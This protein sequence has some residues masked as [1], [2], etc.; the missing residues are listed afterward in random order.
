[1]NIYT[2]CCRVCTPFLVFSPQSL[3]SSWCW[4][5]LP[6]YR[7]WINQSILSH[8]LTP[9][10]CIFLSWA[11]FFYQEILFPKLTLQKLT[12][13]NSRLL[14]V[15]VS[16]LSFYSH[17]VL[18]SFSLNYYFACGTILVVLLQS[19]QMIAIVFPDLGNVLY[20]Q[21]CIKTAMVDFWSTHV[22]FN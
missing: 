9:Q 3:R 12:L 17:Q 13:Q 6:L 21:T 15:P 10:T 18:F 14:F 8:L 16:Y 7:K 19:R 22:A 11:V 4:F 1:M 5:S 20:Y 2:L